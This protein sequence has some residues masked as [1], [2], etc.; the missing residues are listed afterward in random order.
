MRCI[1]KSRG[2]RGNVLYQAYRLFGAGGYF[3]LLFLAPLLRAA[4]GRF[5]AGLDQRLARYPGQGIG[6]PCIW[7]HAASVG[8]VQAARILIGELAARHGRF[9]CVLTTMTM[10]GWR[11]AR[12]LLPETVTCLMAPLDAPPAVRRAIRLIRPD[13]YICLETELWPVMLTEAGR[14]GIPMLLLNGRMSERSFRRYRRIRGFMTRILRE[15]KRLGVIGDDDARRFADLGFPARHIQVTGNIKYDL[16]PRD[17]KRV[18][19]RYRRE[20]D[21]DGSLVFVSG[22]THSG[23]E[24]LLLPVYRRLRDCVEL[25]VTWIVVPRHL[26][27]L[28]EV[29]G[30]LVRSGVAY[31]LLSAVRTSGRTS[32]II[33]VDSM[34]ELADL[35]AAADFVFCGGSLVE[36]GGHNVM[37]AARWGVPVYFGPSMKDFRDAADLL[38]AAGAGFEVADADILA[39]LILA[40]L[41]DPD[42]YRAIG[43][44]AA[45][46]AGAQGGAARRQVEMVLSLLPAVQ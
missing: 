20:L 24:E 9:R 33:L 10:Q 19:S 16:Q 43:R 42:R 6:S 15:F 5:G 1:D 37:E 38:L 14:A 34:G 18:R 22:S 25:P 39:D 8:E 45:E 32:G 35:Y 26:R 44:L 31:D 11:V 41:A 23:E 28:P 46:V 12:D 4:G 17:Q 29:E 27:R 36:R 30:L 40:H 7:L 2:G 13:L 3:L 21:L